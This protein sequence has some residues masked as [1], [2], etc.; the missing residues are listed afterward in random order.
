LEVRGSQ[1][2]S[3]IAWV[4]SVVHICVVLSIWLVGLCKSF[5]RDIASVEIA[6]PER[7]IVRGWAQEPTCRCFQDSELV[8][9]AGVWELTSDTSAVDRYSVV[10]LPCGR[11]CSLGCQGLVPL[12]VN[13]KT[14]WSTR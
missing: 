9:I 10:V 5:V 6:V 7:E 11:I 2:Y 3:N 1:G 14:E 4:E 12:G 13:V 8:Q